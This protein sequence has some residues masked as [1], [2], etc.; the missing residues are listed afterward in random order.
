MQTLASAIVS[1]GCT[2]PLTPI[3]VH[4]HLLIYSFMPLLQGKDAC[5]HQHLQVSQSHRP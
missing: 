5:E 1:W 2:L 4:E 3:V